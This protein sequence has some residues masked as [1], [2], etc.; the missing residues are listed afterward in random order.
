MRIETTQG[1]TTNAI[2][3]N[4]K[5]LQFWNH[6]M[7]LLTRIINEDRERYSSVLNQFPSEINVGHISAE[8]LRKLFS[9][10][11]LEHLEEHVDGEDHICSILINNIQQLRL[12][13]EQLYE[14]IDGAQLDNE[15]KFRFTEL[16]K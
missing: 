7:Y 3:L 6:F 5:S 15:T 8:T 12:N 13:L 16:Q 14:L 11:L 10:N 2:G 1:T 4:L 9:A